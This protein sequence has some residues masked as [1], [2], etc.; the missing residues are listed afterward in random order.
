[1]LFISLHCGTTSILVWCPD[2]V[3]SSLRTVFVYRLSVRKR[4][5]KMNCGDGYNLAT[6]IAG[7]PCK[8]VVVLALKRSFC[9][10]S[11]CLCVDKGCSSFTDT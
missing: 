10:E 9:R 8:L 5:S 1:M 6:F 3:N 7:K 4:Q 2:G 11:V